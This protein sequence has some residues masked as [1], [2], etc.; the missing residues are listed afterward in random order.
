MFNCNEIN[1]KLSIMVSNALSMN[2]YW[3]I[4]IYSTDEWYDMIN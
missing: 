4:L 1:W 3:W 2:I